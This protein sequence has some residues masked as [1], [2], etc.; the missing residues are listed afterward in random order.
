MYLLCIYYQKE[1][2]YTKS[3]TYQRGYLE[4]YHIYGSRPQC[5]VIG[6]YQSGL[7]FQ[8][9]IVTLPVKAF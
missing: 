8:L 9:P 2:R 6:A 5:R 1:E 7:T 3:Q 4:I